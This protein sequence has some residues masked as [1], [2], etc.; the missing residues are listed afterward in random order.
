MLKTT[1]VSEIMTTNLFTIEITDELRKADEIMKREQIKH[2]PVVEGTKYI[3]IITSHRILEYTLRHLYDFNEDEKDFIETRI[4]DFDNIIEKNL[5][6][7]YPEDSI[8]KVIELFT[9][10]KSDVLPVVDW[11]KNL[12]GLITTTDIFLFLNKVIQEEVA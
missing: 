3:G 6:L 12:L 10:Y 1:K 7:L 5:H 8:M 2:V 11:D 4:L 9:K